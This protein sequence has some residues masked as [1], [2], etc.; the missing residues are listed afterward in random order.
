VAQQLIKDVSTTGQIDSRPISAKDSEGETFEVL[1]SAIA[2]YDNKKNFVGSDFTLKPTSSAIAETKIIDTPSEVEKLDSTEESYLQVYFTTQYGALQKLL[3]Q[4][5]GKR[6]G[7]H[8]DKIINETAERNVWPVKAQNGQLVINLKG[9]DADSYRALLAKS[10][11]YANIV[12]GERIVS[13]E[14]NTV[15]AKMN[16]KILEYVQTFRLR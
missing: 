7:E 14:M 2:T 11:A 9:S 10:V 15:D 5:G 1:C 4:V 16:P 12:I 13:R 8:L 3:T 6:L